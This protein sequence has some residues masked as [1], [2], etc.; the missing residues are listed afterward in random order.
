[1]WLIVINSAA[2]GRFLMKSNKIVFFSA[3]IQKQKKTLPQLCNKSTMNVFHD[4][5]GGVS[6]YIQSLHSF[7]EHTQGAKR[8]KNQHQFHPY[9]RM[10]EEKI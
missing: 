2:P 3:S 5:D 4:D 1:M 6:D 9:T 7:G 10:M 8:K